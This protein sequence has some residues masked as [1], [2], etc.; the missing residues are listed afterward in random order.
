MNKPLLPHLRLDD[1]LAELQGR[2]QDVLASRD[3]V[4]ALLD[5]V[6]SIGSDLDLATMLRRLVGA[7]TTLVDAS[8]GALGVIGDDGGL[9][10]FIPVGLSDEEIARIEHWPHGLGLLG[11][12]IKEPQTLRLA[13]ISEHPDSFGFPAGHPPMGSF[14]GVPI[15]VRDEVFGNL[16]LTEKRGGADFDAEDEIVVAAL[17]TAA[18]VAIE[19]ARLYEEGRRRE[20]WLEASSEI[21]RTLLLGTDRREVLDLVAREARDLAGA[22]TGV[23]VLP[24][25]EAGE[26]IVEAADGALTEDVRGRRV[27]LAGTLAGAV[28]DSGEPMA[29]ADVSKESGTT[30]PVLGGLPVGPVLIVPL[31]GQGR[32]RGVLEVANRAGAPA[33]DEAT[34]R[35][36]HSFAGQA[37]VALELAERRSD[38]ERLV[39]L[40]DRDRI[41]KDLHDLV[42]QRLFATAMTLM[43][44]QRLIVKPEAGQRVQ[45]AIDD[46]DETIR[47]IRSTIFALQQ[48]P[49]DSAPS[50][51]A[52]ILSTVDAAAETLGFTPRVSLEGLID[53]TVPGA[54]GEQ[55]LAVLREGLS[56]V[57]RHARATRVDVLIEVKDDLLVRIRDDG[58][59]VEPGG[60]RS[61]L[62]NLADRAAALGGGFEIGRGDPGGTLLDWWVPLATR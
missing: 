54:V 39:V 21:T 18:G 43:S 35:M 51:R 37:A 31:G 15:R 3:R 6:V 47:Q 56:N 10:E 20:R 25:P 62:K 27:P 58:I 32:V 53:I 13:D 34:Q 59:G 60:R 61:G 16:Y 45:R 1:L 9:M 52:R 19:N 29:I 28:F 41:A 40:E 23:I 33:F 5:A 36:V 26:L 17:A 2:L 8:Y 24:G 55:A 49:S 44:A 11:L 22:T 50:L 7:A 48:P 30:L 38:T 4:H 42:I 57:A 46:L 14:L 12:L